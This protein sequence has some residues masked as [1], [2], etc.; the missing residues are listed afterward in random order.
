M[1]LDTFRSG[2]ALIL[3]LLMATC[4]DK[5]SSP[6]AAD[7]KADADA[8][9]DA[10][11]STTAA[12]DASEADALDGFDAASNPADECDPLMP[13]SCALPW[14]SNLYLK[15]D[16]S[17]KTGYT[18][19]FGEKSLPLNTDGEPIDP[20]PYTRLD[21]YSVG[22]ALLVQ[23]PRV[24]ISGL[25]H[26]S[27]IGLSVEATANVLWL[28]VDAAGKLLRRIPY[29]VELD[30]RPN[31]PSGAIDPV[32]Q[33]LMVRPGVVLD[34]GRRYVVA[35]RNLKDTLGKPMPRSPAF[36]ALLD[37]KA[38][39]KLAERQA[40]FQEIFKILADNGVKPDELT[41]AWDFVTESSEALHE[42]ILEMRDKSL[43]VVGAL[44]PD[45]TV[46]GIKE[47]ALTEKDGADM[48]FDVTGTFR[49]PSFVTPHALGG[50]GA[51]AWRFNLDAQ[52]KLAQNGWRDSKFW[53]R[54]PRSCLEG[55]NQ[56]DLVQYGHGLNGSGHEIFQSWVAP[57]ANAR[58]LVYFSSNMIGMSEEDSTTI[59][60]LFFHLTEFAAL[61]ERVTQGLIEHLLLARTMQ[62]RG[63]E[64]E[65]LAKRG[66]QLS[67]NMYYSGNSQGGIYGQTLLAI[68]TQITRGHF[69]QPGVNY[70]MLMERSADFEDYLPLFL[71]GYPDR[72]DQVVILA[73]IQLLWDL[74]DPVAYVRH[75]EQ[76]PLPG[77]P[78]HTALAVVHPGDFQV[79]PVTDEISVRSGYY[80]LMAHYGRPVYGVTEVAYPQTTSA[81][82]AVDFGN[83]WGDTGNLPTGAEPGL[84]C[85]ADNVPGGKCRGKSLCDPK[86]TFEPC[87]LEDPHDR[88]HGLDAHNDQMVHFFHTGEI[89]DFC[90]GDGCA[91]E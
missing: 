60:A 67:G 12:L 69:G 16:A 88:A 43:A 51:Q 20:M 4:G 50:D 89:A 75:I 63:D 33:V 31:G 70:S 57:H 27:S 90:G 37:G 24:D 5:A 68:H 7:A 2:V 71:N 25:A 38:T 66:V 44:G 46:T 76:D 65:P 9:A 59:I 82:V 86:G 53:I 83:T 48:A 36:Q 41:L 49:A 1:R 84:Q 52:G 85:G 79:D 54:V 30:Q 45:I 19:Q 23:F 61:P 56:C 8:D 21:G 39:G 26:Q 73:T 11:D 64:L 58:H 72:R 6:Q 14:P 10:G 47:Y 55:K 77:T 81:L 29:F 28:E 91:P 80:K 42:P 87:T 78:K 74:V 22:S 18:L 3:A 34:Y 35:F 32:L 13:A 40:R 17:R 62:A 15:A